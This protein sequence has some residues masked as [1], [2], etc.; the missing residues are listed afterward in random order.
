MEGVLRTSSG[1][2]PN[3]IA[4]TCTKSVELKPIIYAL[5]TQNLGH[6]RWFKQQTINLYVKND[7]MILPQITEKN[8]KTIAETI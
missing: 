2:I 6:R 1:Q 7:R 4:K 8:R 3:K 5:F